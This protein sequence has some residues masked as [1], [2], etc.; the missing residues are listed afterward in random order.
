M[1][2]LLWPI[3]QLAGADGVGGSSEA[4]ADGGST[5]CKTRIGRESQGAGNFAGNAGWRRPD[6]GA[7]DASVWALLDQI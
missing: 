4:S 5:H 3:L 1:M 6:E 2:S 7:A